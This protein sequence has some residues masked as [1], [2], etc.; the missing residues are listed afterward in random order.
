MDNEIWLEKTHFDFRRSQT[1]DS[2]VLVNTVTGRFELNS[3]QTKW[4]SRDKSGRC[5]P[6]GVVRGKDCNFSEL[7]Y[8][9]RICLNSQAREKFQ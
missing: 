4:V 7:I 5:L 6:N 8:L 9:V 2:C 3:F 1:A